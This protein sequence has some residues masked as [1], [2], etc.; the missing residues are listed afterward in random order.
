MSYQTICLLHFGQKLRPF[1]TEIFFGYLHERAE[2]ND[3]KTKPKTNN[4][5]EMKIIILYSGTHSE[6]APVPQPGAVSVEQ[7]PAVGT[8]EA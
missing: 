2:K 5:I 6:Q 4:R 8:P 7:V 1:A 3:P